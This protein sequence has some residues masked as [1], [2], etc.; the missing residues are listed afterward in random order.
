MKLVN[1]YYAGR[2]RYGVVE[3]DR[4]IDPGLTPR[5]PDLKSLLAA[6]DDGKVAL[7]AALARGGDP[8]PLA[9]IRFLPVIDNPGKIICVGHNY[10]AHRLETRGEKTS[11]PTLF[12]RTATSQT[13]HNG[14]LVCPAVS[15][16]FD[17][18]G[19]IALI[20]GRQGRHIPAAQAMEHVA[21]YACYNDASV[22][23]WQSHTPQWTPGKNFDATGSFGPWM[24]TRDAIADDAVLTL[25]TR[26]NG[27]EVQ[28][29][30]TEHLIRPFPALIA[31]ISAFTTL[32]PGD[33]IVTGTPGGIGARRTPPLFM[34]PGDVVEVDITHIGRLR[35][36]VAAEETQKD[37]Q[38]EKTACL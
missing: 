22:R 24:V 10:E 6:G 16:K 4:V 13:G 36:T 30:T 19:E 20:I 5:Y 18:E 35:N 31:Y 29:T 17:F 38:H 9:D 8:F 32:M 25:V 28:R 1:F 2:Q 26:L 14:A 15:D 7:Q 12:L 3:G 21:G 33:V 27:A 11:H 34:G 23:D 37:D